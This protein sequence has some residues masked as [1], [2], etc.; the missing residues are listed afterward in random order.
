MECWVE[1]TYDS[2][3]PGDG[4]RSEGYDACNLF[5]DPEKDKTRLTKA[6]EGTPCDD[7][8]FCTG[9][10]F[11][12]QKDQYNLECVAKDDAKGPCANNFCQSVCNNKKRQCEER[13]T[14]SSCR[15]KPTCTAGPGGQGTCG[16]IPLAV[17]PN[18]TTCPCDADGALNMV[19]N[20]ISGKCHERKP[21]DTA[22]TTALGIRYV[23]RHSGL[24]NSMISG[25]VGGIGG[26]VIVLGVAIAVL[27]ITQKREIHDMELRAVYHEVNGEDAEVKII[28]KGL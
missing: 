6:P 23:R 17:A 3:T 7:G 1:Q 15:S 22:S 24:T 5:C 14:E 4:D 25:I 10:S 28:N 20:P 8:Y 19:C 18:C 13:C 11:C 2:R 21:V 12:V 9:E 16:T 26:S 27:C